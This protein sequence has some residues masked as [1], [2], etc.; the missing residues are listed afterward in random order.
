MKTQFQK[1]VNRLSWVIL[2]GTVAWSCQKDYV[3]HQVSPQ[4]QT[5]IAAKDNTQIVA[6]AQDIMD[7][8]AGALAGQGVT[9]GSGSSYG[10][11][12]GGELDCA[13]SISGSF[14]IDRS[15]PDSV[16]F[17]GTLTIDYG[18]GTAC[19]DSTEI[20]KGKITD[21]FLFIKTFTD[22]ASFSLTQT[23]TFQGFQKDSV[24]IDGTFTSKSTS[25]SVS[26]LDIQNAKLTYGDGTFVTWSGTLT[27]TL[28]RSMYA[29]GKVEDGGMDA[30]SKEV[31][32]SISGTSRSG[33]AF[34][35]TI[36]SPV[37]FSY[38]CSRHIP[39][40]GMI[41]LTVG[42]V[43]SDV[44]FGSGTCDKIYTITTGGTT[45]EYVFK[46]HHHD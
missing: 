4:A 3:N 29:G 36:T 15:H 23:V 37:L 11:V 46:R 6:S 9:D 18:S 5:E 45:T 42:G 7:V 20:R 34:S 27:T 19:K 10:R 41:E 24:Q 35:A 40:S 2:F 17:S 38:S 25:P 31:T 39:V 26:I 8:T 28:H 16:I 14:N 30:G 43:V 33:V 44:D 12:E 21:T 32:G 13:P 22:S 1:C